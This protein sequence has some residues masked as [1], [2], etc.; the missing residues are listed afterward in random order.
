M[1]CQHFT[2]WSHGSAGCT[3][4][5]IYPAAGS[6]QKISFA[7]ASVVNRLVGCLQSVS[8]HK[9]K[10]S[11]IFPWQSKPWKIIFWRQACPFQLLWR[12]PAE[13]RNW[14]SQVAM[15]NSKLG[16]PLA[17]RPNPPPLGAEY[18]PYHPVNRTLSSIKPP[19]PQLL[20]PGWKHL[21][22]PPLPARHPSTTAG[23]WCAIWNT[24]WPSWCCL[25]KSASAHFS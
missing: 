8:C 13:F 20:T 10:T 5:P 12:S 6:G 15:H 17:W 1:A 11:L 4:F 22:P 16:N 2:C 21:P 24:L 14:W 7:I 9:L 3:Y 19:P 25:T 23:C 18:A